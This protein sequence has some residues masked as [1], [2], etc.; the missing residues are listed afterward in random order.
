MRSGNGNG[1]DSTP[2]LRLASTARAADKLAKAMALLKAAKQQKRV[3]HSRQAA[4]VGR[5][6]IEKMATTPEFRRQIVA[7]LRQ[8]CRGNVDL[9]EIAPLLLEPTP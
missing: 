9:A 6:V 5:V 3:A 2:A 4:I 8:E 7:L 1:V